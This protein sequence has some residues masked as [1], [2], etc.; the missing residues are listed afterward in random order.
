M[1]IYSFN[2]VQLSYPFEEDDDHALSKN[3]DVALWQDYRTHLNM[4]PVRDTLDFVIV[5]DNL[6]DDFDKFKKAEIESIYSYL[7]INELLKFYLCCNH[8]LSRCIV[9]KYGCKY[10][11]L[12]G[13]C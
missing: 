13:E 4:E 10:L 11:R 9:K 5:N 6:H 7:R 2:L 8:Q 12:R 1:H 3:I